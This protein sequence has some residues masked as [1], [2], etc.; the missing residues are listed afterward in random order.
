MDQV[1]YF[2][3]HP[4]RCIAGFAATPVTLHGVELDGHP[5]ISQLNVTVPSVNI[6]APE[7]INPVFVLACSCGSRQHF[8]RGFRWIN[9]D[10]LDGAPVF[11]SPLSLEC[12]ACGKQTDLIDTDAHGYDAELGHILATARGR[13]NPTVHECPECGRQPSEVF[14]RFEYPDDLFDG[15]FPEFTGREQDLFTWFSLL[16]KCCRCSQL[17]AV[18][19]FECA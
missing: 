4:P 11:L 6:D 18:T 2:R 13:G 12:T 17:L 14:A 15:D 8:V 7:H 16:A 1:S 3:S 9:P 19:D 5:S 10:N